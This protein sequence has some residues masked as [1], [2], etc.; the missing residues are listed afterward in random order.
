MHCCPERKSSQDVS[1]THQTKTPKLPGIV[2]VKHMEQ[3]FRA[4]VMASNQFESDRLLFEVSLVLAAV[5][6]TLELLTAPIRHHVTLSSQDQLRD[7]DAYMK[8]KHVRWIDFS[9]VFSSF[10]EMFRFISIFAV[11]QWRME[12]VNGE[13]SGHIKAKMFATILKGGN[14]SEHLSRFY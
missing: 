14:V 7:H 4:K 8:R 12:V 3:A 9:Y 11:I 1:T 6:Q 5:R 10:V 13:H 2:S